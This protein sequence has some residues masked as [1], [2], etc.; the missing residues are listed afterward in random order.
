ML[1]LKKY[2][3]LAEDQLMALVAQGDQKAFR[4][5][6][7]R[8]QHAVLDY[9]FRLLGDTQ[10][11]RDVAQETMLRVYK[12]AGSYRAEGTFR[13]WVMRIARNQCLDRLRRPAPLLMDELPEQADTDTPLAVALRTE[14]AQAVSMAVRELPEAQRTAL[15]L[16]HNEGMR[17]TQIAETMDISE[18][19]VES[20]LVRAR[21]GLRRSLGR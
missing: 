3:T 17:Y 8:H 21:K 16:R 19:A 1:F 10:E 14:D 13:A 18:G 5:L 20:L 15:I 2:P 12:A 6:L 9:A 4:V 7:E 11:A